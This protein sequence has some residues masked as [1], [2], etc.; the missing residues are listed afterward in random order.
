MQLRFTQ[1]L[2]G[3]RQVQRFFDANGIVLAEV[4][5]GGARKEFDD[6][7]SRLTALAEEQETHRINASGEL[8]SERRLARRLRREH[9]RPIVKVARSKVPAA[10]Q[11]SAVSLPPI[12]SNNTDTA[13]RAR[14][15]A[16][17]VEPYK[18]LL[19]EGGLPGDFL[20]QLNAATT[21]LEQAVKK[22][23]THR[24][25]RVG[26]TDGIVNEV[27]EVR[28]HVN[29]MD[30]LVRKHMGEKEPAVSEW[31]SIVR[32]IRAATRQA[33]KGPA[34]APE[35]TPAPTGAAPLALVSSASVAATP[36]ALAKEEQA[37]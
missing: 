5:S 35:P 23:L 33:R 10:A 21:V 13:N 32:S 3:V 22:K 7:V 6:V 11:L 24:K 37:A 29:V 27:S 30:S 9:M 17:A 36:A 26:S 14:A 20:E 28:V 18:Q 1:M 15:M 19:H 31:A 4:N 12:R 25:G 2:A 16:A 34:A 8:S